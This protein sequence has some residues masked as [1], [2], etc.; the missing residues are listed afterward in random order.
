M[1]AVVTR[2]CQVSANPVAFGIYDPIGTHATIALTGAGSVTVACTRGL[3]PRIQ[4][5]TGQYPTGGTRRMASG[6]NRLN[7]QL[8][9]PPDTTPGTACGPLTNVWRTNVAQS[10]FASPSPST[11]P[12]TWNV[13]G[14]V[15]AG[16]SVPPGSYADTVIATVTF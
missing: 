6:A 11:A 15:A 3:A 10:L 12:R 7:Y 8:Y 2:N 1:G 9:K 4:L 13:C 5:S 16:Q 14:S